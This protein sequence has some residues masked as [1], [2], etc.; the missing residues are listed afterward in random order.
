MNDY[1]MYEDLLRLP[2]LKITKVEP[3]DRRIDI[4]GEVDEG[5]QSCP[6]CGDPTQ[7]VRMYTPRLVRDLDI[8]GRQVWLHLEVKQYECVSCKRYFTQRLS[9]A[10]KGKSYTK[11][12]AKFIF[13]M[14]EQQCFAQVG[15]LVDM[16]AKSVERL[17]ME[18]ALMKSRIK[19]RFSKV[20]RLGIDELSHRKGRKS[21]YCALTDLDRGIHLDILPNR[22][23]ETLRA[24]FQS[25]GPEWC[26]QVE[27]VSCDM[28]SPY[29][30]VAEEFFP[31]AD[32]C[33]DRFHVVVLLNQVLDRFRKKLRRTHPDQD[34]Y[35]R[36]KWQLFKRPENLSDE[37]MHL[38]CTALAEN[39]D[40]S[41]MYELR[42]E[43]HG[44]FDRQRDHLVALSQLNEW[45][46]KAQ[47]ST[48]HTNWEPFLRTLA[49]WKGYILNFVQTGLTNAAT[50]GLNNIIRHVKRISFGIHNFQHLRLRVLCRVT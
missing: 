31:E 5:A 27:A 7:I 29:I 2:G 10:M 16:N 28:W 21:Y 14:C 43:F 8:S 41:Q 18:Y 26:A 39:E 37:E 36:I 34:S 32:I 42:N 33:I 11:R 4:Y 30:E 23:K 45:I 17:Y 44:I 15:V 25:L 12:Q 3:Q 1:S 35:K 22:K 13:E 19:D 9:W 50:E 48:T 20:G 49:N 47:A 24:Y 6:S 40:L 38:L 46:E